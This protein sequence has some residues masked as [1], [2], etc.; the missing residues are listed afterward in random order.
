MGRNK[1]EDKWSSALACI[2]GPKA[3]VAPDP[4]GIPLA[5]PIN[6]GSYEDWGPSFFVLFIGD[7]SALL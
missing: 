7:P 2:I 1:V 3:L 6:L 5:S 4:T